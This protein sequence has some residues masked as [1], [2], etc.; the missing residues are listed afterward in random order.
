MTEGNVYHASTDDH[1]ASTA[2]WVGVC[3]L[4]VASAVISA[5]IWFNTGLVTGIG[6]VLAVVLLG[7]AVVLS[8]AGYG[9]AAQRERVAEQRANGTYTGHG[10]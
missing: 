4:I 7:V 1:G 2:A 3:G 9:V 8:K 6:V 5:G 10:H